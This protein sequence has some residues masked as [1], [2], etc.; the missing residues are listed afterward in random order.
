MSMLILI[1]FAGNSVDLSL[2]MRI[3]KLDE[4][5]FHAL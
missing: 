5:V 2:L 4:G 1:G 3:S